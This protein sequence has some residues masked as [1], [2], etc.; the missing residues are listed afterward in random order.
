M[1][2]LREIFDGLEKHSSDKWDS[3]FD[4]YERHLNKFERMQP[5]NI[6]EVGTQK[7]GSLDMWSQYFPHPR[8]TIT[9]I[10]VDLECAKLKYDNPNISVVIGDQGNHEFWRDF[11]SE[12]P[13][14][15]IFVDDGGHFMDQQIITFVNVF[16]T[17]PIGSIYICEDTHTSF[18]P[19]N[20]GGMAKQNT[21]LH[22]AYTVVDMLHVDWW[23]QKPND[24]ERGKIE[25]L[26]KDLTSVHFYDSMVVFEK[27]GKKEMKRVKPRKY[28]TTE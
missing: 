9:G 7:G 16:P 20:G 6:V 11:L 1:T 19:Y 28:D 22:F 10:D 4:V 15:D 14:I 17:M 13:P 23:D 26:I 25:R 27:F 18:M 24:E 3:Y 2:K 12:S 21:F 5:L 8:T